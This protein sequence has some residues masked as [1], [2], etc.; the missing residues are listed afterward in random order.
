LRHRLERLCE[1]HLHRQDGF[2]RGGGGRLF[3]DDGAGHRAGCL[4]PAGGRISAAARDK[5]RKRDRYDNR[6]CR[7]ADYGA[8]PAAPIE[9][10][11]LAGE[12]AR[13]AR[14]GLAPTPRI[15]SDDGDIRGFIS[16][17]GQW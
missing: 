12:G 8:V 11:S 17:T 6:G 7:R 13:D 3:G 1:G 4:G 15:R 16:D 2:G 5:S 10:P 14:D 9:R